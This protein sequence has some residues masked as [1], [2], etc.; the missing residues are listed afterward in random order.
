M[1]VKNETDYLTK[2][3]KKIFTRLAWAVHRKENSYYSNP[4]YLEV[5]IIYQNRNH[6][7]WVG[8]WA[9]L[10][11]NSIQIEMP[12]PEYLKEN[13]LMAVPKELGKTFVHELGHC[14]GLKK[15]HNRKT[16]EPY[17]EK[18]IEE[19][20]KDV[21]LRFKEVKEKPKQDIQ[22][23]RWERAKANLERALTRFARA[24]TLLKKWTKKVKYYE[25][26]LTLANK[27]PSKK[28]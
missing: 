6:G 4:A 10:R 18:E 12:R 13:D 25:K 24:K 15:H 21:V 11:S 28:D 7:V 22:I 2:D 20:T 19:A 5:R 3:L 1:K 26:V 23:L 17:F 8:G 14:I 27:I 16:I 9:W